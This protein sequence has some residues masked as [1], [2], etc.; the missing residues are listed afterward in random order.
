MGNEEG[1]KSR[2]YNQNLNNIIK[3]LKRLCLTFNNGKGVRILS[4]F[5]VNRD[6]YKDARANDGIYLATALSN[7]HEAERSADVIITLYISDEDRSNGMIKICNPKARR[8]RPFTPFHACVNLES[9]YMFDYAGDFET[10]PIKN[11]EVV[12]S[13]T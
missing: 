5:Q 10:D 9:K 1:D 2:D 11:M 12:I 13:K 6:G 3:A 7:A 8:D 4:P